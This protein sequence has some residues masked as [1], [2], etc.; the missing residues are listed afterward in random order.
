MQPGTVGVHFSIMKAILRIG[1]GVD[2]HDVPAFEAWL[3]QLL[4][5]RYTDVLREPVPDELTALIL[6]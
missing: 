4:R 3:R 2:A 1:V 5:A 6:D